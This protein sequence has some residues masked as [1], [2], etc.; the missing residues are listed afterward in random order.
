M[1]F[2]WSV[3]LEYRKVLLLGIVTT[4]EIFAVSTV[5]SLF[6]GTVIG[7]MRTSHKLLLRQLG[8]LYVEVFR[9]IPVLIHMMFFYFVVGLHSFWAAVIGLSLYTGGY[10]AETVRAG[11]T[12]VT[13]GQK[14]AALASGLSQLQAQGLIVLPQA[15]MYAIPPLTTELL[16]ILKN[17]SVAMAV[18][19]QDL[20]FTAR[21]IETATFRGVEAAGAVTA[22]YIALS[23]LIIGSIGVLERALGVRTKLGERGLRSEIED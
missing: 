16:N 8:G 4:A 22:L 18:G 17:S 1:E 7:M 23:V 19:V 2:K 14:E 10:I 5:V 13:R 21:E 6:L 9:N 20:T 12:A 15:F 11:I 3:V